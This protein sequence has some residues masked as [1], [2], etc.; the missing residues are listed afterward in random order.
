MLPYLTAL[1]VYFDGET[2]LATCVLRATTKNTFLRKKL[3]PGDLAG[4]FSDL[5]MTWLLY[6]AGAATAAV[7]HSALPSCL[8]DD[9]NDRRH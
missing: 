7:V 2:A 3:H 1:F 6:C 5:D 8:P 4:G 9:N